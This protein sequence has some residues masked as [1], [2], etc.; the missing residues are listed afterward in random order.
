MT[1]FMTMFTAS[2]ALAAFE[3]KVEEGANLVAVQKIAVAMPNYYKVEENEPE[4]Q[5]LIKEIYLSGKLASTLEVLSY[6]EIASAIRRDTGIDIYALETPEA[7]KVYNQNI[8]RYVD[9]YVVMTIANGNKNPWLSFNV[10]NAANQKLM[11][12][13][14]YQSRLMVKNTVNY[15]KIIEAF[16]NRFDTATAL[17]LSKEERKKLQKKQNEI[18]KQKRRMSEDTYK[19]KKNKV[20][21]VRKK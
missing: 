14:N 9:A 8:S 11:Y 3:E 12:T 4:F 5:D 19:T 6:E 10:C 17:S 2:I 18:R 13:Y 21:M 15:K 20:E 1:I 7:E 16:F